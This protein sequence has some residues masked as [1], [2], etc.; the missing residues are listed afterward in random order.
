MEE[1]ESWLSDLSDEGSHVNLPV[2]KEMGL[3]TIGPSRSSR[4]GTWG[5]LNEMVQH[6]R[7][8]LEPVGEEFQCPPCGKAIS[9]SI[10]DQTI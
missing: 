1:V 3:D 4:I 10:S 7:G 8:I 6:S 9:D 5:R 2:Q